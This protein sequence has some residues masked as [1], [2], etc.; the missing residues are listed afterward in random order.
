MIV[1]EHSSP[2]PLLIRLGFG[3]ILPIFIEI[4]VYIIY[5]GLRTGKF[6]YSA[7]LLIVFFIIPIFFLYLVAPRII[8][9][10]GGVRKHII[11]NLKENCVNIFL[12][13]RAIKF[14]EKAIPLTNMEFKLKEDEIEILESKIK[15]K[16][17]PKIV[18]EAARKYNQ[19]YIS[20][21]HT[22]KN[23]RLLTYNESLFLFSLVS[24]FLFLFNTI[25]IIVLIFIKIKFDFIE[26]DKIETKLNAY[27]FGFIF[28]VLLFFSLYLLYSSSRNLSMLIPLVLP[29]IYYEPQE[30]REK[31]ISQIL[32]IAEFPISNLFL[33]RTQRELAGVIEEAKRQLLLP[34][35]VET[36]SWYYRDELAKNSTWKLYKEVLEE[37]QI[38]E[39]T[40]EK[41]EKQF[42]Y[43]P[44]F[45]LVSS[46]ILTSEEE[47]AIKADLDYVREKTENWSK[48]R[49]E[50]QT[51]SFLLIYRTLETVFRK[52]ITKLQPELQEDEVNFLKLIDVLQTKKLINNDEASL[53]HEIRFKR[54]VLFHSPGKSIDLGKDTVTR[55]LT[56]ISEIIER[57]KSN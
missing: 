57:T 6:Q 34:Q 16:L 10:I 13:P 24:S 22:T 49:T 20:R 52:T 28:L 38:P 30:E 48:I 26:I 23:E 54:N 19:N 45:Q 7:L 17:V 2:R 33:R 11:D 35:L 40:K 4:L 15:D 14:R 21:M 37:T 44:L 32:S 18:K 27:V 3:L 39:E 47:Q 53:L 43:D 41:I 5:T 50:E 55:L 46:K 8:F 9:Y 51:L 56:L 25:L 31:R 29:I 42:R 1:N 12:K 36:I